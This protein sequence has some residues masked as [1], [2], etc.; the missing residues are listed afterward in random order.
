[1]FWHMPCNLYRHED[2]EVQTR[3]DK[4]KAQNAPED[5]SGYTLRNFEGMVLGQEEL[6][7]QG[8]QY[9]DDIDWKFVGQLCRVHNHLRSHGERDCQ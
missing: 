1:M 5:E 9:S 8:L 6:W 2:D 3:I 4:S 7:Q